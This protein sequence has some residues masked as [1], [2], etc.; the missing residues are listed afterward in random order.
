MNA[1]ELARRGAELVRGRR[2][3]SAAQLPPVGP[4]PAAEVLL[5]G[6]LLWPRLDSDPG[7]VL[8]LAADDIA[9]PA[10]AELLGVIRSM[11]AAGHAVGPVAV[12]DELTRTGRATRTVTD[13]LM[14]ATTSGAMPEALPGYVCAVLAASLRRRVESAGT[15]LVEAAG[16]MH[17]DEL[18]VLAERATAAI[19][20]CAARLEALRGECDM[21]NG[22]P[23]CISSST[24]EQDVRLSPMDFCGRTE[25]HGKN[26]REGIYSM[27]DGVTDEQFE[28]ALAEA[29]AEGNLSRANVARKAQDKA[30]PVV[31][32]QQPEP[33]TTDAR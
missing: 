12:F 8:A 16:S 24:D 7:P 6:A 23:V 25:L 18:P 5:I 27:T 3:P 29:R 9:D 11:L 10:T 33:E 13:R 26:G 4:P 15:A 2:Q 28:Q 22:N 30:N 21:R 20:D 19:L 1:A 32:R 14:A 31:E 17:E